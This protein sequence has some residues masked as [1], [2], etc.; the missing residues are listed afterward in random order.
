MTDANIFNIPSTDGTRL[1]ARHWAAIEPQATLVLIHGFGEHSGRYNHMASHLTDKG[2]QVFA[3]DLRGHGE[4]DGKRGVIGDYDEFRHD[5]RAALNHARSLH[6]AAPA[7]ARGPFILMG[8]SM[9]G[10]I[11]LDHGLRHPEEVDG[12]IATGPLLRPKDPVPPVLEFIVRCLARIFPNGT[13]K[14]AISGIQI[15]TLAEEQSAYESDPL[16]H[17]RLGFRLAVE[18]FRIGEALTNSATQ[19]RSPL[20]L[21]HAQGDQLTDCEASETFANEASN[22]TFMALEDVEHE[23]HNDKSRGRVYRAILD[24]IETHR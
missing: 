4:S 7:D 5:L 19:W 11:A 20:L 21:I 8:H 1:L 10:G 3:I 13:M 15:S 23:V 16:N 2:V 18:L 9:G 22:V 14:N 17:N 24:F 6:D 12:I